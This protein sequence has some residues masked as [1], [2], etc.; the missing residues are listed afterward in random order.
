M[1]GCLGDDVVLRLLLQQLGRQEVA[2]VHEHL[3]GCADCRRLV[4]E[5]G[6]LLFEEGAADAESPGPPDRPPPAVQ[7]LPPGTVVSRYVLSEAIGAGSGGVVY[8][9]HDPELG[10]M[11]ALKLVRHQAGGA[12]TWG[13]TR[14]EAEAAALARLSHPNVVNVHDAGRFEDQVFVIMELVEGAALSRWL[15]ER[16][17]AW[18]EVVAVMADAALGL[19]AAHAAGL[20][21]RDV[22]PDNVMVGTDG[23]ARVTDFGLALVQTTAV[24]DDAEV[25]T[26]TT[27]RLAGTPAYMAPEVFAGRPADAR[28]DQFGFCVTLYAALTGEHPFDEGHAP[29]SVREW[30]SAISAG[31]FRPAPAPDRFPP[32]VYA[33]VR[34]G[35]SPA[36]QD[37]HPSMDDLERA[38]R[39]TITARGR[40]LPRR[41]T[42]AAVVLGIAAAGVVAIAITSHPSKPRDGSGGGFAPRC[43]NGKVDPGEE[44][45]PKAPAA[46]GCTTGCLRCSAG[47]GRY[48]WPEN[49]HC[50]TRHDVLLPWAEAFAAC[51]RAGGYLVAY[52]SQAEQEAVRGSLFGADARPS[53]IGVHDPAG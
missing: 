24:S 36:P 20:V 38:L 22:K 14:V 5:A 25:R 53:W 4:A 35:L 29:S 17:R 34:R 15:R 43:G 19:G 49:G 16:P 46:A 45:D 30:A 42:A 47:D 31:A 7:V 21:H 1:T 10:R 11:V 33:L 41:R 23:R 37:R 26:G 48:A 8:R 13:Q 18:R 51:R 50:Y 9:A 2:R 40:G 3:E 6:R 32:S 44:C 52:S 28:S 12:T 27:A 39:A